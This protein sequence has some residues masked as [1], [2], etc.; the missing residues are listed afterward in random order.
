M[1]KKLR[2][3]TIG[4]YLKTIDLLLVPEIDSAL[5]QQNRLIFSFLGGLP[6][7]GGDR[8]IRS[9]HNKIVIVLSI[10]LIE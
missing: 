4:V 5:S 9:D 10:N 3:F 8:E 7:F 1:Q 2:K 6:R